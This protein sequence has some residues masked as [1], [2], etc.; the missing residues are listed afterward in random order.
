MKVR[1]GAPPPREYHQ[2]LAVEVRLKLGD[3]KSDSSSKGSELFDSG[4]E[5]DE[6]QSKF[7][8]LRS[9]LLDIGSELVDA[10]SKN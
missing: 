7:S 4:M 9:K 8:D 1:I 10:D 5:L 6:V 2:T 3:V